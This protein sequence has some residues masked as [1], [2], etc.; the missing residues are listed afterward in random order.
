VETIAMIRSLYALWLLVLATSCFESHRNETVVRQEDC[1][2]CHRADYDATGTVSYPAAP[3]HAQEDCSTDCVQCHTTETWNNSLG[4]CRHPESNFPLASQGTQHTNIK[5]TDCHSSSI[6][7]ATGATSVKGANTDCDSCHPDSTAMQRGHVG[8]IYDMGTLS[9]QPYAYSN[10][11]RRFCLDCHPKGLPV[12]HGP[13]NPFRIP[14]HGSSCAQC[15]DNA[16]GLGHSDGAD[17]TCVRSGCHDGNGSDRAHEIGT[18]PNGFNCG[19]NGHH[20][21]CLAAGCH[22][23]G[24][25][26]D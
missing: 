5:C 16:S 6:T 1:Y 15:H 19:P 22:F 9:G 12:G 17:V 18:C 4:G 2:T 21:G 26:H 24:R 10:T 23:D 25:N 3:V 13:L 20:P 8:V 14:H 11:D 7:L